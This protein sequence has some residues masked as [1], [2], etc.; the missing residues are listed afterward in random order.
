VDHRLVESIDAVHGELAGKA[1]MHPIVL[2]DDELS[3]ILA[4]AM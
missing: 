2:G 1:L 4:A 3:S